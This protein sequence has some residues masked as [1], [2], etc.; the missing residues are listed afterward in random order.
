MTAKAPPLP[1]IFTQLLQAAST[2]PPQGP[3][4]RRPYGPRAGAGTEAVLR[5]LQRIAPATLTQSQLQARLNLGR[6]AVCWALHYL[7]VHGDI[8]A[9]ARTDRPPYCR[10]RVA[11]TKEAGRD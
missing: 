1:S 2:A 7:T 3:A 11:R 5:E 10:Y 8:E 4:R 9:V 6:G